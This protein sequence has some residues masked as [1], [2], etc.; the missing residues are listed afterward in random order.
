MD[1]VGASSF[2]EA[3]YLLRSTNKKQ[4]I[5]SGHGLLEG[6][7]RYDTAMLFALVY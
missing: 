7:N 6:G 1:L 3:I 5:S 2:Q 4:K